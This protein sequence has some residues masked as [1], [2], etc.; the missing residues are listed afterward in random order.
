MQSQADIFL[1]VLHFIGPDG[2]YART[3]KEKEIM[4][5]L[6]KN[7]LAKKKPGTK[8]VY[9]VDSDQITLQ[10]NLKES[11]KQVLK[12]QFLELRTIQQPFVSIEEIRDMFISS[13]YNEK[14][15]DN[16]LI[17]LYDNSEIELEKSFTVKDG[18]KKGLNYKNKK[19]FSYIL[20]ID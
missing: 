12:K 20:S 7:R 5:S 9:I 3:V 17:E 8:Q 16:H 6:V 19:Y 14:D 10:E 1:Q 13:G 18:E 4:A 11:F 2:Y 15:F